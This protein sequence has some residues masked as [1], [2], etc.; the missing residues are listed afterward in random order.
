MFQGKSLFVHF[1]AVAVLL[2]V[3]PLA[4]EPGPADWPQFRG[5]A[6]DGISTETGLLATWP[7]EGPPEAWRVEIGEG[8]SAISIVGDRLYT[9]FAGEHEDD[10]VEFAAA[11]EASTGKEVWRT[12]VGEKLD[13]EFGNGPRATPTIDGDSLYVLGSHGDLAALATADGAEIWTL[14]L[15]EAFGSQRPYW[16]FSTSALVDGDKLV[17]EGGGGEGKSYAALNKKTGEVLWTTGDGRPGHNSPIALDVMGKRRFVY[18]AGGK[19]RCIDADGGEVWAHEWPR[20]ET[21]ASP[22]FIAPNM[23]YASG[24]EGIGATLLRVDESSEDSKVEELWQIPHLRNHFSTSVVHEGHIYGFD[25]ATFKSVSVETGE[26]AWAKRGLGKGSLIY[27]D[28][29]LLVLSD[30]GKLVRAK[31]SPDGYVESGNIEALSGK[32]WTAP[33]LANGHLYLRSHTE[34]VSYRLGG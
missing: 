12:V 9:M 19:L 34:M 8:Y 13:T 17:I 32:T 2:A 20:G 27:A 26:L 11:F 30:R 16:G 1:V 31:A 6:R 21:H 5:S 29:H 4:A 15:T 33:T 22:V 14:S 28:G 10:P 7:E 23:I 18:V 25:N 3:A 24:A